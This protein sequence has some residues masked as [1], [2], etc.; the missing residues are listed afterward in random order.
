M[1]CSLSVLVAGVSCLTSAC[2]TVPAPYPLGVCAGWFYTMESYYW[3]GVRYV[4]RDML[5]L[6]EEG[7]GSIIDLADYESKQPFKVTGTTAG[8]NLYVPPRMH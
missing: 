5:G 3:Q 7:E 2:R 4:H 1:Y 6:T 8:S